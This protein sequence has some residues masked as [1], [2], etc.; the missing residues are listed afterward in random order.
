MLKQLLALILY[1]ALVLSFYAPF[2]QSPLVTAVWAAP[3]EEIDEE[4]EEDVEEEIEDEV[5]DQIDDEVDD[6]IEDQIEDEVDDDIDD[7]IEDEVDDEIEDQVEDEVDDEIEDEVEDD[8]ETDIEEDIDDQLEE[9]IEEKIKD[10]V[11]EE[12]ED[13]IEAGLISA[14]ET[15]I[16]SGVETETENDASPRPQGQERRVVQAEKNDIRLPDIDIDPEGNFRVRH[17][18][19]IFTDQDSLTSL[20][21]QGFEVAKVSKLDGLGGL[22]VELVEPDELALDKARDANF[23]IFSGNSS[24]D[25]NH[26]FQPQSVHSEKAATKKTPLTEKANQPQSLLSFPELSKAKIKIGLVDS[27]VQLQHEAFKKADITSRSFVAE[28][29]V[30][31]IDHGTAV[32]SILCGN[33]QKYRGLLPSTHLLA[34]SVFYEDPKIGQHAS[35]T[36][37]ILALNWL[38]ESGVDVINMSLTGPDN[39]V[40]N[41]ALKKLHEKGI[42]IVAAAGNSG[43]AGKPL[44]PAA[45]DFVVAVTAVNQKQLAFHMANR[46]EH[47]DVSAPGV[48]ILHA[49][50]NGEYGNSSGTS[51][52]A[53]FV[54]AAVAAYMKNKNTKVTSKNSAQ[55]LL[56]RFYASARDLGAPGHD[57]IYGHGLV[58]SPN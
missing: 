38:A 40:L 15:E 4:V 14:V 34:A 48:N 28:T 37:L 43:P 46:G 50:P 25:Y 54:T 53:P 55:R 12:V 11:E 20:K 9:N 30:E 22:L 23:E 19:I 39:R 42:L 3:A 13:E 41:A 36:S 5:E 51:F 47:I 49:L 17:Q 6:D 2:P 32:A 1:L 45:Y 56:N 52:A 18:W 16:E 44:Y 31:P 58:Q 29:L 35:V 24:I 27:K 21:S 33:S 10:E 8:I 57:Q 26:L 7:Q